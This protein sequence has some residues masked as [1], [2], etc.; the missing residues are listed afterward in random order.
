MLAGAVRLAKG[1]A[2]KG[3]GADLDWLVSEYNTMVTTAQTATTF[4]KD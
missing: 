2:R 1:D 4:A 3:A